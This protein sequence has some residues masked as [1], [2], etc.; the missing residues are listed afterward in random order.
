ML[1][2]LIVPA[3][4]VPVTFKESILSKLESIIPCARDESISPD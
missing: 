2:A 4:I 3:V 1:V